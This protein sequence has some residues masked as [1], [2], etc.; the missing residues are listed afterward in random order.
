MAK[1]ESTE[2]VENEILDETAAADTLKPGA[3]SNACRCR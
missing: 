1:Q 2:I 3:G